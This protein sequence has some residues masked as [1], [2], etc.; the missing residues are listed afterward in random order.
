MT[1]KDVRCDK[2]VSHILK[3]IWKE[4]YSLLKSMAY[5]EKPISLPYATIKE[6]LLNHVK[7]TRF[8]CRERAKFYKMICQNDQKIREFIVE[9]Q[10]QAVKCNIGDQLHVQL[11]DQLIAG[12]N[13]PGLERELLGIP[14]CSFQDARTA[15]I[16][17]EAVN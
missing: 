9:L 16:N 12:I 3:F 2:I 13:I 10:K 8:E 14:N 7:C 17:Y 5:L 1:K 11:T 15:C 4:A 6:L